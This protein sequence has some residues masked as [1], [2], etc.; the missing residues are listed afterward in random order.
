[1]ETLPVAM[2]SPAETSASTEHTIIP[3][4]FN[5]HFCKVCAPREDYRVW[6]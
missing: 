1:L 6:V 4:Q 3:I 2:L 5:I